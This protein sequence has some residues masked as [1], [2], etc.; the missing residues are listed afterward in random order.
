MRR[1][2]Q[3]RHE[4]ISDR[5][6]FLDVVLSNYF[7]A[8]TLFLGLAGWTT[9]LIAQIVVTKTE[10]HESVGLLWVAIFLQMGLIFGVLGAILAGDL[11]ASPNE[12]LARTAKSDESFID[13]H[14]ETTRRGIPSSGYAAQLSAA[15]AAALVLAV[16]SAERVLQQHQTG[17]RNTLAAGWILL[18]LVDCVWL[19]ACGA[20]PHTPI[21]RFVA[22]C[23]CAPRPR[24][25]DAE[26]EN[27]K[28][29]A[30]ERRIQVRS[31]GAPVSNPALRGANATGNGDFR[32]R[33]H[34]QSQ[35]PVTGTQRSPNANGLSVQTNGIQIGNGNTKP[36]V[37][38]R[39]ALGI[40]RPSDYANLTRHQFA[41]A[42]DASVSSN[43]SPVA[44]SF[45]I[46][47]GAGAGTGGIASGLGNQRIVDRTPYGSTEPEPGMDESLSLSFSVEEMHI[48]NH[49]IHLPPPPPSAARN[50]R[51]MHTQ[52]YA[53]GEDRQLST[54]YD[55]D[56]DSGMEPVDV[57]IEGSPSP[58]SRRTAGRGLSARG[59]FPYTVRAKSD[60]IPRTPSE[61]SFREGELLQSSEKDG[62]KWWQV[63]KADGSV[64]SA[65][66]NYLTV[67]G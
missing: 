21:G 38:P 43:G 27:G 36:H 35:P 28:V 26:K 30:G 8:G 29:A 54:I 48:G 52:M 11:S 44:G 55:D 16:L 5:M 7:F 41:D 24:T 32:T 6:D 13:L 63:R 66:S 67:L 19:L 50:R 14:P 25:L 4:E 3:H 37:D 59:S 51:G 2:E 22:R 42:D 56:D 46:A 31:I 58:S 64:G 61:I 57:A 18:A 1:A 33:L 45:N 23:R 49:R 12:P 65:P 15:S 62:K 60:W 53:Q 34:L 9:A 20:D 17:T 10:S 39:I 40:G 47:P